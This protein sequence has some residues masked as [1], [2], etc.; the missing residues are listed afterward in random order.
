MPALATATARFYCEIANLP[1]VA[2]TYS[3]RVPSS[4]SSSP[5]SFLIV[6]SLIFICSF[7]KSISS[8]MLSSSSSYSSFVSFG[9]SPLF[10][11]DSFALS[12]YFSKVS[13]F[14]FSVL[15]SES[16]TTAF[17]L[18]SSWESFSSACCAWISSWAS[19]SSECAAWISSWASY[20]ALCFS[21]SSALWSFTVSCINFRSLCILAT[22]SFYLVISSNDFS[23]SFYFCSTSS[24]SVFNLSC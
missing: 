11:L 15:T 3:S 7:N 21:S 10:S 1:L 22:I 5:V 9:P 17:Y 2:L 23:V 6:S 19:L 16:P 13:I 4:F 12:S 14:N 24:F 18:C 20:N 8:C